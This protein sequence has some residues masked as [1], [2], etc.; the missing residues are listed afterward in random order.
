V[1]GACLSRRCEDGGRAQERLFHLTVEQ[2]FHDVSQM[3]NV[4]PLEWAL[5]SVGIPMW[6]GPASVLLTRS[7]SAQ[8]S[9]P[10]QSEAQKI[11]WGRCRKLEIMLACGEMPVKERTSAMQAKATTPLAT[12]YHV[13]VL[14]SKSWATMRPSSNVPAGHA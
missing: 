11:G 4:K 9:R 3:A 5:A 8:A 12:K 1:L 7:P 14:R 13:L 10:T 6:I 2:L